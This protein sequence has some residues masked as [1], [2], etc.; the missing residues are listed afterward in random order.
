[1]SSKGELELDKE[2]LAVRFKNFAEI[3]CRGSSELY[4]FLAMQIAK[5]DEVLSLA[6]EVPSGQP[7]PNLLFGA[8]HYLLL[9]GI[10]HPLKRYY[11]SVTEECQKVNKE[12]YR[13]FKDFC[14]KYENEIIAILKSK[15]VQTNEVRRSAYLYP[16]FSWIHEKTGKALSIVEIGASA[17]LLLLWD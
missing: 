6:L 4:E 14:R 1:M 9:K 13:Y 8:V 3:E 10:D 11:P 12:T 15:L 5:D 7:A 16:I 2:Q 17:G